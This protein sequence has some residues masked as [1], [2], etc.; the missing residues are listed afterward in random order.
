MA[1][2]RTRRDTG[3]WVELFDMNV[4]IEQELNF[5]LDNDSQISTKL[6]DEQTC[7]SSMNLAVSM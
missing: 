6:K 5:V 4:K 1:F 2:V 7:S 3:T